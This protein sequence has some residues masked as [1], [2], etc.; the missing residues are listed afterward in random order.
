[1]S[2]L[3]GQSVSVYNKSLEVYAKVMLQNK[4]EKSDLSK[5]MYIYDI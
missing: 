1:M 4:W 5:G 2:C 3:T